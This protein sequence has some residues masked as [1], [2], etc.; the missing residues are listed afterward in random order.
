MEWLDRK[1]INLISF[2]LQKFKPVLKSYRFRCNYCGD[3]KKSQSK[4]RGWIYFE[5]GKTWF[6]CFNCGLSLP[7][8]KF[9]Q[10]LDQS[11]YNDYLKELLFDTKQEF[12]IKE[13]KKEE[14]ENRNLDIPKILDL[15][16]NHPA[17]LYCEGR[18]LPLQKLY[19]APKFFKFCN[20]YFPDKY[21]VKKDEPRL[22]IPFFSKENQLYGFQGRSFRKNTQSKYLTFMLDSSP[23]IFGL[24]E[25]T[26]GPSFVFEG[27]LDSLFIKNSIASCGGKLTTNLECLSYEKSKWTIVYDN[28][29]RSKHTIKKMESAIEEG[30]KI[31]IWPNSIEDIDINDMILSGYTPEEIIDIMKK[32]SHCG[33][34]ANIKLT[35][36]KKG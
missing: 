21:D 14:V 13:E 24:D 28:E 18:K 30:Y 33:L 26:Y 19:Y 8:S 23:K 11:L 22:I 5:K 17:R 25:L 20:E 29:P 10:D 27:P 7:F 36:W 6:K 35:E 3:S 12:F 31:V 16:K 1:Y 15:N 9:L 32:N 4:S 2:R 34:M